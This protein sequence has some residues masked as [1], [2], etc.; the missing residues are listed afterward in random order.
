MALTITQAV[1]AGGKN[2]PGDV[3]TVQ[4]LLNNNLYRLTP[5]AP[6]AVDGL[7]GPATT[8]TIEEFQRRALGF[9]HPDGRV[10]PN[11]KTLAELQN[12]ETFGPG[13]GITDADYAQTAKLLGV[14]IA[15][16]KAVATV[17]SQGEGFLDNGEPKILFEGHWFSRFTGGQY[18]QSHPT[19]SHRRWTEEHYRG[20]VEEYE[21][22][23]EAAALDETAAMK[24]TSWGAFQIMGFNHKDAGYDSVEDFVEAM[25]ESEVRQ[26]LALAAFINKKELVSYLQNKDWEA[27]ARHYNGPGYARNQ[28]DQKLEEAYRRFA[29]T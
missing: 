8:G 7:I 1:G 10:D 28:Y 17:E 25:Q 11:G 14:D 5:L 27:F 21:R 23:R 20:G 2:N 18:D 29:N 22:Y 13:Q 15:T 19:L 24:S 16:L 26:L 9:A 3:R 6:L 4:T 12:F